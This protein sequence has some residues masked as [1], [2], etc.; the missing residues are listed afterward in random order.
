[1]L[2]ERTQAQKAIYCKIPFT[3]CSGKGKTKE[4]DQVSGGQEW[5]WNEVLCIEGPEAIG[6]GVGVK[7][8]CLDYGSGYTTG[9]LC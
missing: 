9:C 1:M 7:E 2:N 6:V 5:E 8:L 3:L 4:T